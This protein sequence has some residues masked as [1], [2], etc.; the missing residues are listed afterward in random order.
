MQGMATDGL[1]AS[2]EIETGMVC[3]IQSRHMNPISSHHCPWNFSI[4]AYLMITEYL[5][6]I[7]SWKHLEMI[8]EKS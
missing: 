4:R 8:Q 1:V 5:L 7:Y 3:L 2:S 6:M